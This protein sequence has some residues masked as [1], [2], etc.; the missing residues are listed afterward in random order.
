[1]PQA[2]NIIISELL[3]KLV[4]DSPQALNLQDDAA[5]LQKSD[6]SVVIST[7]SSVEGIHFPY[8]FSPEYIANRVLGSALSDLAAMGAS[9]KGYILAVNIPE[10]SSDLWLNRLVEQLGKLQSM[11]NIPLLGGD[12]VI[13]AKEL[14]FNVTVLGEVEKGR[15]LKRSSANAGDIIYVS[16]NIGEGLIG[17][18]DYLEG[19][20]LR[21][22][23][24]VSP[25]PRLELGWRLSGNATSCIDV[26]DG[27]L[28]DL[29]KL[30]EASGLGAEVNIDSF[31]FSD[32]AISLLKSNVYSPLELATAGDDYELIFT[33]SPDK[34]DILQT[35]R[36]ELGIKITAIGNVT[37][38][39]NLT[40]KDKLGNI[41]KMPAILGYEHGKQNKIS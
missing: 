28:A 4:T 18:S 33:I 2:E 9:P 37:Y 15:E 36:K 19:V 6:K 25:I 12:T 7:D 3:R 17:L 35:I 21:T 23:K 20:N 26:S 24:Y 8:N 16:G 10:N 27:L 13:G 5:V 22:D 29:S 38:D 32:I 34:T 30:L 40:L 41:V 1:M 39:Q 14:S 31:P 11:W